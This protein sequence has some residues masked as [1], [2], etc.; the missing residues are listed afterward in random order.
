MD[1]ITSPPPPAVAEQ[2][3]ALR[4]ALRRDLPPKLLDRNLL[5]ATWRW[6]MSDQ[7]DERWVS[8]RADGTHDLR[9]VR[10]LAEVVARFD[11][12][13]IQGLMGDARRLQLVMDVLG[14]DWALML[15]GLSRETS[16][17]ERTA[18]V[19]DLRKVRPRG[20]TGQVVL[21]GGEKQGGESML[22]SQFFRPP[23]FAAFQ[24][25]DRNFTLANIHLVFGEES[26]RLA[27]MRAFAGWLASVHRAA[28]WWERNLIA[29]GQLQLFRSSSAVYRAFTGSGLHVPAGLVDVATFV[30]SAGTPATMASTIAWFGGERGP[31]DGDLPFRQAGVFDHRLGGSLFPDAPYRYVSDHRPVWVEFGVRR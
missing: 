28:S 14:D 13:A 20:L 26:E 25:L 29:L 16:Y 8:G 11:V 24:C 2:L 31:S 4:S 12:V 27:E 21:T 5:V 3:I 18:F 23:L 22:S 15:T 19:F 10:A 30:N 1:Q 6:P 7:V 9:A 17:Q